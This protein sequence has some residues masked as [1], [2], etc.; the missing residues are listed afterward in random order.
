MLAKLRKSN[1]PKPTRVSAI[2]DIWTVK[3][4][5]SLALSFVLPLLCIGLWLGASPAAQS[6]PAQD[7]DRNIVP[8]GIALESFPYPY[9][10]HF[11]EFEMGGQI[12]RMAY[13][14]IPATGPA[15]GRT[16]VLLHGKN[17][18]GY[19]WRNTIEALAGAGY[20]VVVPDQVGWGKSSKPDL[21]YS[22]SKLAAN[23]ARL[24][25]T[26]GI[27]RIVLLG[28]STGGMLAV[29]FARTY[30]QR[31]SA[32]VLEDPIGLEDY[33]LKI[34]PQ[35][36]ET[37]FQDELK[38]TDPEKIQA[39]YA[40]YFAHPA[41]DVYGPLAEIQIRVTQSGEFPRWAKASALA[42]QMIYEQPVLYD[43]PL[44]EPPTLLIV[45]QEDHVAPL[46]SYAASDVRGTLGHVPELAG[47]VIRQVPHGTL[48][49]IPDAG[50][51]PHL[52]QPLR[53]HQEVLNFLALHPGN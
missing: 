14:D 35:T 46:S 28:H 2:K 11:L 25:D 6:P 38:N 18:G 41:A 53:F 4:I 5:R 7:R 50:H 9:P 44:L 51:I 17:F 30:P 12:V 34:P 22:F 15:N 39:F 32:L 23:T 33:R 42:Y 49:V 10:V 1:K 27:P 20:R 40:H 37:I 52:E 13:M 36:D 48:I 19:Y 21:H 47:E 16:A 8:L 26:L 31:V 3:R 29:R 43:Y 45:G 24:L